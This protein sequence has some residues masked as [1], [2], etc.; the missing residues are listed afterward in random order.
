MNEVLLK[1]E[2]FSIVLEWNQFVRMGLNSRHGLTFLQVCSKSLGKNSGQ[3]TDGKE[4]NVK[5]YTKTC[6][7]VGPGVFVS[8]SS[9]P[10]A[11]WKL[12]N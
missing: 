10:F 5:I 11:A 8:N 2:N 7:T 12:A 4:K 1:E 9:L 3:N 6:V